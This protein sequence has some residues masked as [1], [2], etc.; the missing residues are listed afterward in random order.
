LIEE[1]GVLS[2]A[3]FGKA[4]QFHR[5]YPSLSAW[6]AELHGAV[7]GKTAAQAWTAI[8]Q[9]ET[10]LSQS[11]WKGK[12]G[13]FFT[14]VGLRK[15][16]AEDI[17]PYFDVNGDGTITE[18]EFSIAYTTFY[19]GEPIS[20]AGLNPRTNNTNATA[21]TSA[22]LLWTDACFVNHTSYRPQHTRVVKSSEVS[23]KACQRRCRL[24]EGADACAHFAFWASSGD[25]DLYSQD[26]VAVSD[27]SAVAGTPTCVCLPWPTR[28]PHTCTNWHMMAI[29][30]SS[31]VVGLGLTVWLAVYCCRRG[32]GVVKRDPR[33][34]SREVSGFYEPVIPD[35]A[36][37]PGSNYEQPQGEGYYPGSLESLQSVDR[38]ELPSGYAHAPWERA[39][40]SGNYPGPYEQS[41]AR[42]AYGH[43]AAAP[44]P[45]GS[46]AMAPPSPFYGQTPGSMQRQMQMQMTPLRYAMPSELS[47]PSPGNSQYQAPLSSFAATGPSSS[48][49]TARDLSGGFAQSLGSPGQQPEF[50]GLGSLDSGS[51]QF[52][53]PYIGPV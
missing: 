47:S 42:V 14:P 20:L 26:A 24:H 17:F 23:A 33:A 34:Q 22:E 45:M 27:F 49:Q 41:A 21:A 37:A 32:E 18:V 40:S 13:R 48:Y 9:G 6:S 10:N 29:I 39:A 4:L 43:Q 31:V 19:A 36:S 16:P 35:G 15:A 7:N 51:F 50:R 2:R 53:Q 5:V 3:E 1:D 8:S 25:C 28:Q 44:T 38:Q 52:T 46:V 30:I 12:W 11:S